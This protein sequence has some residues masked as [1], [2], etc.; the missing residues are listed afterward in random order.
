MP[1]HLCACYATKRRMHSAPDRQYSTLTSPL[2]QEHEAGSMIGIGEAG[3]RQNLNVARSA[4]GLLLCSDACTQCDDHSPLRLQAHFTATASNLRVQATPS[5]SSSAR[6]RQSTHNR[7]TVQKEAKTPATA[8]DTQPAVTG[9]TTN[10]LVRPSLWQ[11]VV[12]RQLF[13]QYT[14]VALQC[15]NLVLCAT[16][17]RRQL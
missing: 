12:L 9:S 15:N 7:H 2:V 4:A 5:R 3:P 11:L 14:N 8:L 6:E 17:L 13:L 1:A 10:H 16:Q